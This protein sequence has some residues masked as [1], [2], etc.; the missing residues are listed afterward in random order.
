MGFLPG[1]VLL[2]V[3]YVILQYPACRVRSAAYYILLD[4]KE[5]LPPFN[6]TY[7]DYIVH[8]WYTLGRYTRRAIDLSADNLWHLFA[9]EI[10]N[11]NFKENHGRCTRTCKPTETLYGLRCENNERGNKKKKKENGL[12][13]QR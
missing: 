12:Y 6:S 9:R 1:K 2:N 7:H 10:V 11:R 5:H 8:D 13:N 4:P 3:I